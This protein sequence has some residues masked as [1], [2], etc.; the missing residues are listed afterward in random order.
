M[1]AGGLLVVAY[2]LHSTI[3][4]RYRVALLPI[5]FSRL[6]FYVLTLWTMRQVLAYVIRNQ[7]DC[8]W[9]EVMTYGELLSQLIRAIVL[10][11]LR[12]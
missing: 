1:S 6:A 5:F 9:F 12:L 8:L 7:L 3:V 2:S 11:D 10:I 4:Y